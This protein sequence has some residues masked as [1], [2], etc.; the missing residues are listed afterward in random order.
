MLGAREGGKGLRS[1]SGLSLLK[2]YGFL[3]EMWF[4]LRSGRRRGFSSS[5]RKRFSVLRASLWSVRSD[6]KPGRGFC[7]GGSKSFGVWLA[8][9][10][11]C[12]AGLDTPRASGRKKKGKK[13]KWRR[14][15]GGFSL[16][17]CRPRLLRLALSEV[18]A[19]R[20]LSLRKFPAGLAKVD[21]KHR[22]RRGY[23]GINQRGVSGPL[24]FTKEYRGLGDRLLWSR[25]QR[26]FPCF[27]AK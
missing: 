6:A 13:R 24:G 18:I 20:L 25:K 26:P 15:L 19:V 5:G 9:F 3:V 1:S 22:C 4:G 12:C 21:R 23:G 17:F 11:H 8:G 7:C 10:I 16:P 27:V 14:R 2:Y